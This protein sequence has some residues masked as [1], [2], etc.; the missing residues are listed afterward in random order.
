MN[1]LIIFDW[2]GTISDDRLPIY[3]ANMM[4]LEQYGKKRIG[5]DNWM[6][7]SKSNAAEFLLSHNID[8]DI[9]VALQEHKRAF[10]KVLRLGK[11]PKAYNN[12][13]EVLSELSQSGFELKVISS[14][15]AKNL[16]KEAKE[17]K[18]HNLF[19]SMVGDV[20]DKA[21]LIREQLK[22]VRSTEKVYYIGDTIYD[23]RFA[24]KAGVKSVAITHGYHTK[25]KLL[26]E[27]PDMII[28]SL[29]EL[30]ALS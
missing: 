28:D 23:I 19:S 11:T 18:V 8:I 16:K 17:Y 10:S 12:S 9:T 13:A 3:E 25:D 24:K 21:I 26:L 15:P 20:V 30:L 27:N 2:S 22:K 29:E 5:F 14:H 1:K 4:L 6:K 7:N